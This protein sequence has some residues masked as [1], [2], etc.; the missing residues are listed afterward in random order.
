MTQSFLEQH[1][2]DIQSIVAIIIDMKLFPLRQ[3]Q[4]T[5]LMVVCN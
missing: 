1:L 4:T 2:F 3:H 5:H